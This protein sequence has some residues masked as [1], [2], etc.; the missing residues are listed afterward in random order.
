MTEYIYALTGTVL[1]G[2]L[3]MLLMPDG[4]L[5]N[6]AKTAVGI[7]LMLMLLYPLKNCSLQ[8]VS[9]REKS[10]QQSAY[11]TSYSDIIMDIYT[12]AVENQEGNAD[13]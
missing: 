12:N 1:V 6:F 4:K 10:R 3:F 13:G 5:K 11:K 8:E 2:E 7:L 9:F